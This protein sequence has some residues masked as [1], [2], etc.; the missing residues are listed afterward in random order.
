MK[1]PAGSY[2]SKREQQIMELVYQ[3]ERLTAVEAT[4]LLSGKPS[5]STVRTLLRILEE[6]GQLKH[7]EEDGKFVYLPVHPRQAAAKRALKGVVQ[8][9][10]KGS[11]GDVVAT[12]LSEEGAKL[13][14][15]ELTRLQAMIDKAR[16]EGR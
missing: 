1:Q 9:F 12:L 16:E 11:V 14:D 2:L 5:N 8:T 3:R 13:S 7:V 15:D 4:E 6:K 10:F